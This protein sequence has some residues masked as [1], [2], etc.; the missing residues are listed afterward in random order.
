MVC[1]KWRGEK[2]VC[3][4]GLGGHVHERRGLFTAD[5]GAVAGVLYV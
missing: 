2:A 1:A 5:M 4:E 3:M